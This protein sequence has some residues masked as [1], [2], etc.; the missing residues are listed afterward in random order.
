MSKIRD[1]SIRHLSK[2]KRCYDK[3]IQLTKSPG[4]EN[5]TPLASKLEKA[6]AAEVLTDYNKI[7]Q[8]YRK[9]YLNIIGKYVHEIACPNMICF[10][11]IMPIFIDFNQLIFGKKTIGIEYFHALI[12]NLLLTV[13]ISKM[14]AWVD[15][16]M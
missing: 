9:K 13:Q 15:C 4:R 1:P 12:W 6:K 11:M 2:L 14:I 16:N 8:P 3:F 10:L 7:L 5:Q